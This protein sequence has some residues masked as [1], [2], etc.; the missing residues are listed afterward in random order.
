MP[1]TTA[2]AITLIAARLGAVLGNV[3]FGYLVDVACAV[4][5]LLVAGFLMGINC[6]K[7]PITISI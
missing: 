3:A 7:N 2:M 4:P 5:I 1:R 6:I